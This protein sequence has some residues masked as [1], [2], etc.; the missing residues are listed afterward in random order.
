MGLRGWTRYAQARQAEEPRH[1]PIAST[2]TLTIQPAP[3][4]FISHISNAVAGN[5]QVLE[6]L[7][8][9]SVEPGTSYALSLTVGNP[10]ASNVIGANQWKFQVDGA[11]VALE[12]PALRSLKDLQVNGV[13]VLS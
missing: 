13:K 5:C 12:G 1:A 8:N 10:P 3:S 11:A 7:L 2:Q 6:I 4:G 9:G